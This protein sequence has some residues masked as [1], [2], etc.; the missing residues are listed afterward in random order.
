M[1]KA[2]RAVIKTRRRRAELAPHS[3]PAPSPERC[4]RQAADTAPATDAVNGGTLSVCGGGGDNDN[5]VVR[6]DD[7]AGRAETDIR[8]VCSESDTTLRT[9]SA[10]AAAVE[11]LRETMS[12]QR[13]STARAQVQPRA[14]PKSQLS[15]QVYP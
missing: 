8:F 4:R 11:P 9:R 15:P 10:D 6:T 3:S 2:V 12:K 5:D 13:P 1:E 7:D 14:Y